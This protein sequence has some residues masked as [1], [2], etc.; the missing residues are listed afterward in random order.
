MMVKTYMYNVKPPLFFIVSSLEF[1]ISF[2]GKGIRYIILYPPK[3]SHDLPSLAGL[4]TK[5]H[6]NPRG[7]FQGSWQ[8]IATSSKHCPVI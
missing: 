4:Y 5:Y 2:K 3:C 1:N 6:F 8:H 7:I